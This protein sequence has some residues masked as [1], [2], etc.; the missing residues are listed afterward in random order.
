MILLYTYLIICLIIY[1]TN[2]DIITA[3][4]NKTALKYNSSKIGKVF[5]HILLF[6]SSPILL[7]ITKLKH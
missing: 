6:L 1:N 5:A 7:L 2:I 4:I 3:T